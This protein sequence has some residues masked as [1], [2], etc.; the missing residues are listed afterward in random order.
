MAEIWYFLIVMFAS[1]C[2]IVPTSDSSQRRNSRH[3]VSSSPPESLGGT[4][5][6]G[7]GLGWR[8]VRAVPIYWM[9]I[10]I[11]GFRME[12]EGGGGRGVGRIVG[13]NIIM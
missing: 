9:V 4:G 12:R 10:T 6:L 5:N 13:V 7:P 8:A 1:C 2:D 3:S 11:D